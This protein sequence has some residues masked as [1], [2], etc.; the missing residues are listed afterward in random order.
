MIRVFAAA[1]SNK[2]KPGLCWPYFNYIIV[3]RNTWLGNTT[4]IFIIEEICCN[5]G[6]VFD[7]AQ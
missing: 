7:H 2:N 1:I 5:Q 4:I 3:Y 6:Y